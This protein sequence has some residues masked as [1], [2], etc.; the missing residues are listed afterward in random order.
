MPRSLEKDPKRRASPWRILEHPWMVE[1]KTKKVN[2]S[3]FLRQVWDWTDEAAPPTSAATP[4]S[5]P[6]PKTESETKPTPAEETA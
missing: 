6:V 3:H 5:A 1:M 4:A 2:M